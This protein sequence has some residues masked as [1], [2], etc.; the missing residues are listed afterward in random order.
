M[1]GM[2]REAV[3]RAE[4]S[5]VL[6]RS[7][8]GARDALVPTSRALGWGELSRELDEVRES[9]AE[10]ES[11]PARQAA[12]RSLACDHAVVASSHPA[13]QRRPR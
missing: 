10:D 1:I 6:K 4:S 5:I 2:R 9:E 8:E 11:T 12:L 7:E 3:M 13:N